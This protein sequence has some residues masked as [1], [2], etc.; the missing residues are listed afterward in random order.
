MSD[1]KFTIL[2][3]TGA[4]KTC[5]LL[6]MYYELCSGFNGYTLIAD[7]EDDFELKLRYNRM[8]DLTLGSDRFPPGTDSS[9][10]FKFDF[11]YAYRNVL[12]FDWLDYAGGILNTKSNLTSIDEYKSFISS[13]TNSSCLFICIDGSALIGETI[14]DKIKKIKQES[15]TINGFLSKY[16]KENNLLPPV[17]LIITKFDKCAG[18]ISTEE[19]YQIIKEAYKPLFLNILSD[20][21]SIVSIIPI[22]V[23]FGL[24]TSECIDQPENM[25]LPIFMG[26]YCAINNKLSDLKLSQKQNIDGK[27]KLLSQISTYKDIYNK[28]LESKSALENSLV[29]FKKQKRLSSLSNDINKFSQNITNVTNELDRVTLVLQEIDSQLKFYSDIQQNILDELDANL[30]LFINGQEKPFKEIQHLHS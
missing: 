28:S 29:A 4:G 13:L 21:P 20:H 17:A 3:M 12:S 14:S 18:S 19:L 16:R 22:S 7:D 10:T 24:D 30:L 2:G 23:G 11:Q 25:H 8:L 5:Y 1:T 6:G 9:S 26:I 15:K 27:A